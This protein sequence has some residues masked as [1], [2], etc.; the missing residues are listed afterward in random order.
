MKKRPPI[1]PITEAPSELFENAFSDCL[2][3]CKRLCACG[4]QCFD[5]SDNDWDWEKGEFEALTKLALKNPSQCVGLPHA[6]T[7]MTIDRREWVIGC[8]CNGATRYQKF[9]DHHAEKI[10]KYLK[11]KSAELKDEAE[12]IS[13]E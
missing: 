12:R 10:A 9:I 5:I 3:G 1:T 11:A 4:R 2:S 7:T 6:C 13:P 8:P